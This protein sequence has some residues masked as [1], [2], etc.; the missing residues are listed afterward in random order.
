VDEVREQEGEDD[1]DDEDA[2]S[3]CEE[4]YQKADGVDHCGAI[5]YANQ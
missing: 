2:K 1:Y 4:H 5:Q 3:Q